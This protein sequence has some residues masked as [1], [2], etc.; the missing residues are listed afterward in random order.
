LVKIIFS[1]I[2]AKATQGEREVILTASTLRDALNQL[3][4]RYGDPF[5]KRIF[6]E[7]G[8]PKRFL[9]FYVN[10]KNARFLKYLDTPL[11]EKD[12]VSVLPSVTGG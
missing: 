8:N 10:G 4:T 7:S 1:S 6:D 3:V 5:K 9:N 11:N 2:I 12:E